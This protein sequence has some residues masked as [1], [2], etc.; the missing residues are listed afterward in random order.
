MAVYGRLEHFHGRQ[1]DWDSY[2]EY[3][4]QYFMA[5]NIKEAEK[6][7]TIL[8]SACGQNT[9]EVIHD[10]VA[11]RKPGDILEHVRHYYKP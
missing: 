9:Y 8:L 4:Q 5:N 1:E 3:L 6:Q 2:E 11:L 10:L 7:R